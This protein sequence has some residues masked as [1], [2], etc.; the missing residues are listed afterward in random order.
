MWR[1]RLLLQALKPCHIAAFLNKWQGGQ[2]FL[3]S[4]PPQ[5]HIIAVFVVGWFCYTHHKFMLLPYLWWVGFCYAPTNSCYCRICGGFD[6]AM[7]PQI[8]VIAVFVVGLILL[9]PHKFILLPYLWWVK[10]S[11]AAI[12]WRGG[13][14]MRNAPLKE[15]PPKAEFRSQ[16]AAVARLSCRRQRRV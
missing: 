10:E 13:I 4:N 14:K 12:E 15:P 5:I 3:I 2:H 16:D 9:C 11:V 7:P 6:S 1:G 8:R